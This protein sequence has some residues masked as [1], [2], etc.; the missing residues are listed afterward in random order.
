MR[1]RLPIH[2]LHRFSR[3]P[4]ARRHAHRQLLADLLEFR[5][6]QLDL[7]GSN[8]FLQVLSA[9]GAGMVFWEAQTLYLTERRK[10]MQWWADYLDG[11][12]NGN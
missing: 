9:L 5:S 6:R 2:S 7:D 4:V 12:A 1:D 10:M 8:V 11:V 3:I